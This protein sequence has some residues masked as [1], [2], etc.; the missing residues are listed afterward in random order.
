MTY[1]TFEK[2]I[3][4]LQDGS[5]KYDT[6]HSLG[7]DLLAYDEP[8]QNTISILIAE[9]FGETGADWINWYL[10]EKFPPG[11]KE[12]LKAWDENNNEICYDVKSLWEVIK[13]AQS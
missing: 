11:S 7:I 5:S 6:L 10:Y 8:Y 3:T 12:P 4:S 9:V 2:I 13:D 1:E